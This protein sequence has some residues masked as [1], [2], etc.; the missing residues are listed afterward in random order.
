MQ[1]KNKYDEFDLAEFLRNCFRKFYYFIIAVIIGILLA[2]AVWV[3]KTRLEPVYSCRAVILIY[4]KEMATSEYVKTAIDGKIR[5]DELLGFKDVA[6]SYTYLVQNPWV[7][8]K[9]IEELSKS[10]PPDQMAG[11]GLSSIFVTVAEASPFLNVVVSHSDP[12]IATAFLS[13]IIRVFP[14]VMSDLNIMT[15]IAVINYP[16]LPQNANGPA[17]TTVVVLG[18]LLG[19]GA[20]FLLI[21]FQELCY[22]NFRVAEDIQNIL[23]I[24]LQ[25][26]F[27]VCKSIKKNKTGKF[28]DAVE[29]LYINMLVTDNKKFLF[30]DCYGIKKE[31]NRYILFEIAR[32]M[33]HDG[34][35]VLFID[36]CDLDKMYRKAKEFFP[37]WEDSHFEYQGIKQKMEVRKMPGRK[38]FLEKLFVE[39]TKRYDFTLVNFPDM[40]QFVTDYF[41]LKHID[42]TIL[43][44]HHKKT[45]QKR[46]LRTLKYLKKAG[47]SDN[48]AILLNISNRRPFSYYKQLSEL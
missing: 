22:T 42:E 16:E 48:S 40:R 8:D 14:A 13:E 44:L 10:F 1:L 28:S 24:N 7:A 38:I 33:V 25:G 36:F 37:L 5:P 17:L 12:T 27:P 39:E 3:Y 19:L 20:V 15:N 2:S 21:L 18:T 29:N 32:R 46:A 43:L 6:S 26:V 45:T 41:C 47:S 34:Y 9:A 23:G 11:I 30:V 31:T 4:P 35:R